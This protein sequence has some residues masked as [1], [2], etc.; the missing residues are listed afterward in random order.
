MRQL[1]NHLLVPGLITVKRV[2]LALALTA[3]LG[4]PGWAQS[5]ADNADDT[6][7]VDY[8]F[9][10][11]VFPTDTFTQLLGINKDDKI[12]GYH[13]SGATG[14]PNKGF[15]LR[16]P[17][18]FDAENFPASA[19]TQ[20][21]GINDAQYTDGFYIDS[22]GTNHGFLQFD[23]TFQTVD[24]PGTTFNQLL[25]LNNL[26][27]AAGYYADSAGIDHPYIFYKDGGVFLVITIP[28][29]VGGAQATGINDNGSICG[30]FIDSTGVNHGFLLAEGKL[31][32]LDFP[33]ATFTQALGLNDHTEVVG[34]YMDTGGLTH[35]FVYRGGHFQPV[36]DPNGVGTT[37]INGV[38]DQG[39]LVGFYVDSE[40]NTD[41]LVAT[42]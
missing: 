39:W 8:H 12:A 9:K 30:F 29:A 4:T 3:L 19:Q 13:G 41:G 23:S 18:D 25:G 35:G 14:H 27:Q 10:T 24:F 21:I 15:V 26:D 16:L 31:T 32:Q 1:K 34:D 28:G 20:V 42:P 2:S 5:R 17:D 36:D 7:D 37:T 38:N 40:G 33:A 6:T 22:A 11:I